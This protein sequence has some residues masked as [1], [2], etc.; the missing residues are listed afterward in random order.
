MVIC[1]MGLDIISLEKKSRILYRAALFTM[2]M[3]VF[4]CGQAPHAAA[5]TKYASIVMDADTGLI[6]SSRHADVK[7]HPASLV[8]IMTVMMAFEAIE[9]G[10][11]SLRDRAPISRHAASMIPSKLHLPVGSS[12]RVEDAIYSLVTKSA[13]DVAVALA[14]KIGG[15]EG[16]FANLMTQRARQIGMSSTTF[17]NASGLHHKNQVT[18]AR[19]MAI[20][21][22]YLLRTYPQ[23]YH[24]FSTRNFKYQGKSY[25]NHNRLMESYSGMDG[26][27][28]GYINASGFNLMASVKRGD[29][30]LIGVVFGGRTSRSRNDHMK[31]LLDRGFGRMETITIAQ[32]VPV[33]P[34]KPF[35]TMQL[36][37][38]V[39]QAGREVAS[40]FADFNTRMMQSKTMGDLMGQG[41]I[42][43]G[44]I[45]EQASHIASLSPQSGTIQA[46]PL[47]AVDGNV[48][49][50]KA[51]IKARTTSHMNTDP[52]QAWS[53]Q[54][55]A[56]SSRLRTDDVIRSA[57][58]HLPPSL[59]NAQSV[60]VP[61]K[62][63]QGWIFRGRFT[64]L[65]RAQA[66]EACQYLKECLP[67][68]PEA[69]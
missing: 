29:R 1:H 37:A 39:P 62:T 24:Y 41:D 42:N 47:R 60:I 5:N 38:F 26:I 33:P 58:T 35:H 9:Q 40:R 32:N 34:R 52:A 2:A 63:S 56:F 64:G 68:S 17:K 11:L 31:T 57:R 16:R 69:R 46:Q 43:E 7:R 50:A 27:K 51:L 8:K 4:V 49:Q 22:Q 19:D 36:A 55:G 28:T 67:V 54:V 20:L 6:I 21:G 15:T 65:T 59:V 66:T 44:D 25:H 10:T 18:T 14:E 13:N 3:L 12:I 45:N 48:D 23:Y 53:I 30:R 61:L